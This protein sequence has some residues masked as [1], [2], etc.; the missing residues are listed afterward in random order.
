MD[1]LPRIVTAATPTGW[2]LRFLPSVPRYLAANAVGGVAVPFLL[3]GPLV[4]AVTIPAVWLIFGFS[5]L[6]HTL[7]VIGA[8]LGI[9][10]IGVAI[11]MVKMEL[12][13][14]RWVELRAETGILHVKRVIGTTLVPIGQVRRVEVVDRVRLGELSG[15]DVEF[16]AEQEE[17]SCPRVKGDGGG[18]LVDWL[19]DQLPAVT[20]ERKQVVDRVHLPKDQW[21]PRRHVAALW[22]VPVEAVPELAD[23][24]GVRDHLFQPRV[25][26]FY[27][28]NL[29]SVDL[30]DPDD[31]HEIAAQ[32]KEPLVSRKLAALMLQRLTSLANNKA[33]D[34]TSE[35]LAILLPDAELATAYRKALRLTA[36]SEP[37]PYV[38]YVQHWLC[39]AVRGEPR[40][41][42]GAAA[43]ADLVVDTL[44]TA[45]VLRPREA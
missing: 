41:E 1:V 5:A 26:A 22:K 29:Q 45:P 21:A 24:L 16:H 20:V 3:A 39:R 27:G 43:P 10:G 9:A 13:A 18:R 42:P 19:R 28:S 36:A 38:A 23:H 32:L 30:Y 33:T 25:G 35:R 17:F 31:I 44:A 11:L 34:E 12:R 2:R 15:F 8:L 40:P 6:W 14:V 37:D 4:L 7:L